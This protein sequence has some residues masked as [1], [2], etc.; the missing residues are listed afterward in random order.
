MAEESDSRSA[1]RGVLE[2]KLH[3]QDN[4]AWSSCPSKYFS[5]QSQ[6]SSLKT[7]QI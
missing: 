2:L 7:L 5:R 3:S 4:N 6:T 1:D